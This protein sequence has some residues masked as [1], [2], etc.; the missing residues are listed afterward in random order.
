MFG[1]SS[2]SLINNEPKNKSFHPTFRT[3]VNLVI[4]RQNVLTDKNCL[5]DIPITSNEFVRSLQFQNS[6]G[7][8]SIEQTEIEN[9]LAKLLKAKEAL[10][11]KAKASTKRNAPA[12]RSGTFKPLAT[13][14]LIMMETA[15]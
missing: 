6:V 14:K 7:L 8:L 15:K 3:G 10:E 13:P 12:K 9:E 2:K 11:N 1:H 5:L 4:Q